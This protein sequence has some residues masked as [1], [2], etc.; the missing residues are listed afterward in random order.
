MGRAPHHDFPYPEPTTIAWHSGET[1]CS[2]GNP[3]LNDPFDAVCRALL[4][5][6][7]VAIFLWGRRQRQ[8]SSRAFGGR[9][10]KHSPDAGA[11]ERRLSTCIGRESRAHIAGCTALWNNSH[12]HQRQLSDFRKPVPEAAN[13]S[14]ALAQTVG[15]GQ[16]P[17]VPWQKKAGYHCPGLTK[18]GVS[19][20]FQHHPLRSVNKHLKFSAREPSVAL[21]Y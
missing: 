12:R 4:G 8:S 21:Q 5:T 3:C 15:A 17:A 9:S 20:L 19:S 10:R 6:E 2:A 18:G 1:H 16:A 7:G 14:H 13:P 11:P